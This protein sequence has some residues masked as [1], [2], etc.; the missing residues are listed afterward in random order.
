MR[1]CMHVRVHAQ[2]HARMHAYVCTHGVACTLVSAHSNNSRAHQQCRR[3]CSARERA[4][5]LAATRAGRW[6]TPS[7]PV[8]LA[9]Q[10]STP[11]LVCPVGP[12]NY[13][14]VLNHEQ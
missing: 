2:L 10:A 13:V 3:A 6:A 12:S 7:H 8:S 4:H 11:W 1:A 5:S 14:C 9:A